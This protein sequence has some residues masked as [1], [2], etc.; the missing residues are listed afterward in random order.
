MTSRL[1]RYIERSLLGAGLSLLV[2]VGAAML[3]REISSRHALAEFDLAQS[4]LKTSGAKPDVSAEGNEEVDFSLWSEKR[5]REY[6]ASLAIKKDTPLGV[7]R[8]ERL[9]IRVPIFEGTDDLV[10]NRGVGWIIGTAKPGRTGNSNTGLAGH[11]DGFFRGFK[12][13]AIGDAVELATPG[14]VNYYV[15]DSIEIVNPEDVGV[16][17]PRGVPSL[18]LVTCYPFYFVGAAPQR[19]IVHATLNR[20]VELTSFQKSGSASA[21][22]QKNTREKEYE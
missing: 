11:R 18:T 5:I 9:R 19:F 14:V 13:I 6:R 12:D 4:A 17:R 16:L 22:R 8:L 1:H 20:Q 3:H 15:V 10:L 21:N 7:L 2:M